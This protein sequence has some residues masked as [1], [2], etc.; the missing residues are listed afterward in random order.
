VTIRSAPGYG[1]GFNSTLF[2]TLNT[3]VFAPI[4][5]AMIAI[6]SK[7]KPGLRRKVRPA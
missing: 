7:A 4:P 3:A 6:A 2:T 5:S 1:S